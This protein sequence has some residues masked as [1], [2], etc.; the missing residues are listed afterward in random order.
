MMKMKRRRKKKRTQTVTTVLLLIPPFS[1][2]CLL[3]RHIVFS[4]YKMFAVD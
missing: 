2:L 3:A 4:N 1:A